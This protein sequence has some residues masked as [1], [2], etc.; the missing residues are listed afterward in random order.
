MVSPGVEQNLGHFLELED[1]S[2]GKGPEHGSE[3]I[4]SHIEERLNVRGSFV[5]RL[6]NEVCHCGDREVGFRVYK[7]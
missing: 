5:E 7:G 2:F 1:F 6:H 3:V 4:W